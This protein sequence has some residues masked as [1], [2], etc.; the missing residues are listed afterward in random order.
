[1]EATLKRKDPQ[2]N[3]VGTTMATTMEENTTK[4]KAGMATRATNIVPSVT[5]MGI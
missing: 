4:T 2:R 5:R 1:M 3:F